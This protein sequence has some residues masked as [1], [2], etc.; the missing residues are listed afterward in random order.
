[1]FGSQPEIATPKDVARQ[2]IKGC[3]LV[4]GKA[5]AATSFSFTKLRHSCGVEFWRR[6]LGAATAG[7]GCM[8]LVAQLWRRR[9]NC[10]GEVWPGTKQPL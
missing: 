5:A 3:C 6:D 2:K 7:R 8:W 9:P 4:E 1:V 10:C